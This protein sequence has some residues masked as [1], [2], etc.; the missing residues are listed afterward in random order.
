VPLEQIPG[1]EQHILMPDNDPQDRPLPTF[2][3]QTTLHLGPSRPAFML[4][5]VIR[6]N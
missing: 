1:P 6:N 5:P 2:G 3:G 4:L